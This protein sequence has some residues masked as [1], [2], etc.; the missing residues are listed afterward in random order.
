MTAITTLKKTSASAWFAL[1]WLAVL[2]LALRWNNYAAPLDR[3]E[4]EYAYAAQL[5]V[6]GIPPYDHAFIQKPPAVF[7]SYALSSLFLPDAFW[8]PRILADLFVALATLLLG[9]VARLEFGEGYALPAMSLAT[10]MILLP[11]LELAG[12]NVEI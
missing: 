4:G 10:P 6:Q 11:G 5:L 9:F 7:Y 1:F 2:F 8:S 12:A 3:D